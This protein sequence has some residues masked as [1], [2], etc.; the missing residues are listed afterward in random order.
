[1]DGLES[2]P[3]VVETLIHPFQD[4]HSCRS[5]L[6]GSQ[7]V[8]QDFHRAFLRHDLPPEQGLP[9]SRIYSHRPRVSLLRRYLCQ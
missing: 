7:H 9:H 5:R 1:M 8:N 3:T 6:G 4:V 2:S